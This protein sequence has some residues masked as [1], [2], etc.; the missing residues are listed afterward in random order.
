MFSSPGKPKFQFNIQSGRSGLYCSPEKPDCRLAQLLAP[1]VPFI[2]RR[3]WQRGVPREPNRTS[4]NTKRLSFKF[5]SHFVCQTQCTLMRFA[6]DNLGSKLPQGAAFRSQLGKSPFH[7]RPY[8]AIASVPQRPTC[9]LQIWISKLPL[10]SGSRIR[11]PLK[12]AEVSTMIWRKM[13]AGSCDR[14]QKTVTGRAH[15]IPQLILTGRI[16]RIPVLAKIPQRCGKELQQF[17]TLRDEVD[18]VAGHDTSTTINSSHNANQE[19]H[20]SIHYNANALQYSTIYYSTLQY[21]STQCTLNCN[22]IAPHK[23]ALHCTSY[24]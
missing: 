21:S 16:Q 6:H 18:E 4:A 10:G 13:W 15:S 3:A 12:F 20:L 17:G 22:M 24:M 7:T 2:L 8:P 11:S 5:G 9:A 19:K 23:V 14:S 1:E